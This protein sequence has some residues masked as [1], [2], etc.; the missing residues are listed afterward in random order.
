MK[1]G[2]L[3]GFNRNLPETAY[4]LEKVLLRIYRG[5]RFHVPVW[6][7]L[8]READAW[9]ASGSADTLAN[10]SRFWQSLLIAR[11]WARCDGVLSHATLCTI[12]PRRW[13]RRLRDARNPGSADICRRRPDHFRGTAADGQDPLRLDCRP[14]DPIHDC[15]RNDRR[16]LQDRFAHDYLGRITS[17]S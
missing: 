3:L 13:R 7:P 6:L 12:C 17:N 4:E 2:G 10:R 9:G 16:D 5:L 1:T 8:V 14:L 11:F 15:R